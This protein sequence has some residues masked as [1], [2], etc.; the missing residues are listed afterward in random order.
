M[1]AAALLST[2]CSMYSHTRCESGCLS[3]IRPSRG[4]RSPDPRSQTP[5]PGSW[6]SEVSRSEVPDPRSEVPDPRS[7]VPDPRSR[8]PD[9][10]L[11][12]PDP[13]IPL[14]GSSDPSR[15][16]PNSPIWGP[17]PLNPGPR[18]LRSWIL[19]LGSGGCQFETGQFGPFWGYARGAPQ[20]PKCAF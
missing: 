8:S 19:D 13:R 11:G 7:W 4:L 3:L 2:T 15:I 12:G 6:T 20:T 17:E 5:D 16:G 1:P 14:Y 10:E 9:P 18:P